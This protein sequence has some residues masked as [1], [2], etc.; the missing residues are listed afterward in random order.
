MKNL[1]RLFLIVAVAVIFAAGFWGKSAAQRRNFQHST[2][3]HKKESCN[4]CHKIPTA[5]W[6][7]ARGF[8]D[9][10]DFPGHVACFACHKNEIFS[11][12]RPAFCAGCHVNPGPRGVARFPFPVNS[13]QHQF[14]TIFP[15]DKHQNIIASNFGPRDVAVAHF[16]NAKF[17][18]PD[19]KAPEFNNCAICHETFAKDPK[20]SAR[21]LLRTMQPL[22]DAATYNF[23]PKAGFFKTSPD[24]HASCFTCH[25][26]N[27]EPI[28]TNCAGCHRLTAPY[29]DTAT[30]TR[31]SLKF[32][33][34]YKDH[35]GRDCTSCH[36][37]ITQNADL[38]TMK[39]ADV[40]ILTCSTSSCHSKDINVEI[41]KRDDSI[42]A[43]QPVFQCTYCHTPEIG[44]YPVPA[45]HKV[46]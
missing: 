40:P 24:S 43:K 11:G 33:H 5:N 15:H 20:F 46:Q 16:L 42:G 22:A 23:V 6:V 32:D 12:N 1:F 4:T 25:Y 18:L 35:V 27:Q 9:V 7:A 29:A 41:G 10:A 2:P 28:R 30:V 26:Q 17:A 13:R 44:R 38:K 31:Y 39:D 8:P 36:I 19:D 34:S 45:S 21:K 37:R 3:A 14:S